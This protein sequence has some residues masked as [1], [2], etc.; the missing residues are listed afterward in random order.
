[1]E[2]KPENV[3]ELTMFWGEG[4]KGGGLAEKVYG[5]MVMVSSPKREKYL[6]WRAAGVPERACGTLYMQGMVMGACRGP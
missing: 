4:G 2:V 1:M 3:S 6:F 5:P